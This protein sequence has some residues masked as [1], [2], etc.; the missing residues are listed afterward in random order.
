MIIKKVVCIIILAISNIVSVMAFDEKSEMFFSNII[1]P[2]KE[3]FEPSDNCQIIPESV[4]VDSKILM[5]LLVCCELMCDFEIVDIHNHTISYREYRALIDWYNLNKDKIYWDIIE[6]AFLLR[7][8]IM[9]N[10]TIDSEY[11]LYLE[12]QILFRERLSR[13]G[14][15]NSKE[16]ISNND[17]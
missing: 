14:F 13:N 9:S 2:I 1:N 10:S 17:K 3:C 5:D 4:V 15:I 11:N 7:K 6:E 12:R 8:I 16:K